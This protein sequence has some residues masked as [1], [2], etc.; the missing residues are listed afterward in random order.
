MLFTASRKCCPCQGFT[1]AQ[2]A[3]RPRLS[4]L[5]AWLLHLP[6]IS[7]LMLTQPALIP[8]PASAEIT[9]DPSLSTSVCLLSALQINTVM[10]ELH[11]LVQLQWEF[12][13]PP[14]IANDNVNT[15][16]V[17]S[18]L[19]RLLRRMQDSSSLSALLLFL[20]CLGSRKA[21]DFKLDLQSLKFARQKK[22]K[23]SGRIMF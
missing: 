2:S 6:I 8:P 17:K 13:H 3:G 16:V 10:H 1:V 18:R 15:P 7:G 23:V 14:I 21:Q 12:W 9:A 4:L 19:H 5:V 22:N 11:L 20:S